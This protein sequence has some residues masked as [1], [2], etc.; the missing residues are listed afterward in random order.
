MSVV[1]KSIDHPVTVVIAFILICGIALVFVGRIPVSLNPETEMPLL[2]VRTSY[3]GAGPED[4]EQNVT[5]V[6]ENAFSSLEGLKKMS[7]TSSQG[8]SNIRLEFGYGVN[9]DKAQSEIESTI[10]GLLNRLPVD[11]DTPTVRRFD[12]SAQPIIRLIIQGNRPLEELQTLGEN[13]IQPQLERIKGVATASVD[14]GSNK[15]VAVE[16]SQNRLAAYGLTLTNVATALA[17]QNILLSGGQ[18]IQGTMEYQIRSHES[19]SSIEEMKGLV[20]KTVASSVD[21][22]KRV[23]RLEDLADVKETEDDP[24]RITYIDGRRVIN[25][26]IVRESDSNAV[27]I[28]REVHIA[29]EGINKSLP[30]GVTVEIM[31][32]NTTLVNSVLNEVYNSAWLGILLAIFILLIFLRNI[33]ATFIIAIS[34]PIS[35]LIT[36]LCMYFMGL[37]LNTI[38]LTGLVMGL[39]MIVDA[40]IVI[41]DNIYRYRERGTKPRIAAILGSQEMM[42]A[43]MGSTLTTL[44][45]FIPILLFRNDLG[46]MGQLFKDLVFTVCFSLSASLVVALTIVPVLC[47]PVMHL[48]TR[49]Q[50]PL[51]NPLL[52]RVDDTLERLFSAQE[53]G[54]KK[55]LEFCL[56]NKSLTVTF[57]ALILASALLQMTAFGLNLFPRSNTDDSL[58]INLSLPLGTTRTYTQKILEGLQENVKEQIKGYRKLV[59]SVGGNSSSNAG[60]LQIMLP[61]PKNQIDTPTSIR[62]KLTPYTAVIPGADFSFSTGRHFSS[63]S[64]VDVAIRSKDQTASLEAAK[65]VKR[66]I[67]AELPQVENIGISLEEGSPELLISIDRDRAAM[68]GF[69]VSQIAREMRS[70]IYGITAT[71][72]DSAGETLDVI[73]KLRE[74]DRKTLSDLKSVFLIGASGLRI[75]VS[76]FVTISNSTAPQQINRENKERIIHVTGDLP[77]SSKLASTEMAQIVQGVLDEKY[78]PRETVTVSVGGENMDVD[79]YLP[80]F[81]LII[82]VAVFLVYGVMASQF[83]SFIDPLIIFISIP[84]MFIGVVW[85]YKLTNDTFSLFSLI[86]VVALAGVVVNNGIVLVDYTNTLRA[87]GF[88]LFEACSEAGRHRLRPI[89]MSTLTTLLGIMPLALFP[90]K[91]TESI[92]PI[93]KTMF[94]GL[95]VSSMMTLFLTP[96]LYFIFNRRGERKNRKKAREMEILNKDMASE[97]TGGAEV[98]DDTN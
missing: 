77:A 78:V 72:Y 66:I 76:N 19:L 33:K 42:T 37:T 51:R 59:V 97:S 25:I 74:E 39:G 21:G 79:T 80:V 95:I 38:S 31:S 70:S 5:R 35:I 88:G 87:R 6:L 8:S 23:I 93:A 94:G 1:R 56:N 98:R 2:S 92:Q 50:K 90:G 71:T 49:V 73:V 61:D 22:N 91:G 63:S 62:T 15:I 67:A 4:V 26:Q 3:S 57:V 16:V 29:L 44:C 58:T 18:I 28:S 85:I 48:D 34:I 53:R 64:A 14:G 40:S 60:Y 55:A 30:A 12:L 83:E 7:S 69:S 24:S 84:L 96:V 75:P 89:L 52:K 65:E 11:A 47:G 82:L 68:F 17:S 36:L 43:I 20:I 81:I 32:D 54:Y 9:L 45:V 10:S 13:L 27:Q 86:G 41:L 46:Q